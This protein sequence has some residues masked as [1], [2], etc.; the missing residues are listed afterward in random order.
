MNNENR[1][2]FIGHGGSGVWRELRDFIERRL[3]LEYEEFNRIS[4]VGRA[5]SDRLKEMLEACDMAFIVMTGE[6]EQA[7]G[8]RYARQNVI[9]EAGL[10]QGRLGFERA[11]I[12]LE[13]GC[14]EFSNIH[15]LGQIRFP[16]GNIRAVFEDIREVLERETILGIREV[17]DQEIIERIGEV[18]EG[19]SNTPEE[20][21]IQS[22]YE[23]QGQ[24]QTP[25]IVEELILELFAGTPEVTRKTGDIKKAVLGY[26]KRRGGL[27]NEK[28]PYTSTALA[29]LA[30]K[31]LVEQ[32]RPGYWR[33]L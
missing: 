32:V 20:Q 11:I 29:R 9:H 27:V 6:D 21:P 18:L 14:A 24:C 23:Y 7:D 16:R 5:T 13:E 3:G 25:T 15:G 1:K 19:E 17:S 12:L 26:H 4:P 10:F 33:I 22:E 8:A 31:G 28:S 30:G 2:I